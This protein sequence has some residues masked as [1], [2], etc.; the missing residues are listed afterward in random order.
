MRCVMAVNM[1]AFPHKAFLCDAVRCEPL[2][3]YGA[4]PSAVQYV[5]HELKRGLAIP[6]ELGIAKIGDRPQPALH[7]GALII[8]RVIEIESEYHSEGETM[9]DH[10]TWHSPF[11][12][13]A[14]AAV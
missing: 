1:H 12:T 3:K 9:D 8:E 7:I 6:A 10:A 5:D 14:G 2:V 11:A 13:L 4:A